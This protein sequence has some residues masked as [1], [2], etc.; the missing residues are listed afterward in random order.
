MGFS[1]SSWF[2]AFV[3]A[4]V[5]T[6]SNVALAAE[7]INFD[8]GWK[9]A[10]GHA[11][12]AKKDFGFSS[13]SFSAF[14]KAGTDAG[15]IGLATSDADWRT[16]DLPHDW[17]VELPFDPTSDLMHGFKPVGRDFPQNSIGW[18]RK[19]FEVP[20]ADKDKRIRITFDGIYRDAYVWINGHLLG[21]NESGYIGQ[22]YDLTDFVKYGSRNVIAVRANASDFEGWFYEGA[23]IY[24]HV[25]LTKS[26][27]V[28]FVEDGVAVTPV[29]LGN[30]AEVVVNAEVRNDSDAAVSQRLKVVLRD[31]TGKAV[32]ES[33]GASVRIGA[34]Q[35][36]SVSARV[37]VAKPSLWSIEDPY[38]YTADVSTPTD[39][40]RTRI[41]FRTVVF[42]PDKGLLLNG[43]VV[44]IQGTCNHQDHAGV[45]AAIPDSLNVW[46]IKQLKGF[47][48][49]AYRSSHNP[50]T[51]EV[52]D[53]CDRLGMLVL[54]ET[55]MFG[56]GPEA[57]S[58]LTRLVKRD[59]NHA[60][61][62]FWSIGNEE[63]GTQNSPESARIAKTM[64]N[65]IRELDPTRPVTFGA[66]NGGELNGINSV[67]DVRG[68]NYN[69]GGLDS[70][71]KA[72]PKQHI[73]GSEVGSTVTTRGEYLDDPK[74][75]YVAAYD[76][77]R[78]SWGSTAEAW[79][80]TTLERPWFSGGFVWTGFDYRGEPTPYGWPNVN[81]HFGILDTCGF[82]KDLAFY[83]KAW[84]TDQQVLHVLPHWNRPKDPSKPVDVWVFSN[85][86]AVE[87]FLNS[88][89]LGKQ[90]M[91]RGGHLEWKVPYAPGSLKAVGYRDGK[92]AQETLIQTTGPAARI[93]LE[94]DRGTSLSEFNDTVPV[95]V[96][97][98]DADGRIVPEADQNIQ[99]ETIGSGKIIGV[100][101]GDPSSHEPDVY[102]AKPNAAVIGG[103]KMTMADGDPLKLAVA[104]PDFD[105]AG[106]RPADLGQNQLRPGEQGVFRT[107]FDG[108]LVKSPMSLSVGPIDD[109]G[110]VFLNG[111]LL[112]TTKEWNASH[113]FRVDGKIL[114]GVNEL[115]IV[116]KNTGGEGGFTGGLRLVGPDTLPTWSRSVFHGLAQVIVQAN[117]NAAGSLV[118]RA[119]GKGLESAE[120]SIPILVIN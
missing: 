107:R 28:H 34:N 27:P 25:W 9:F 44:R 59:R 2:R 116:V 66:N 38:L 96:K 30:A 95:T 98:V 83:Y 101:N 8:S 110:W 23:G 73:H 60:S 4:A 43:K 103:W 40:Y 87:L 24:R 82:E 100:G 14:G 64:M 1:P 71:H 54:D 41:G 19:S 29:V 51:P 57:L 42:D 99:F 105:T 20:V 113:S 12:D 3:V 16:I 47:G 56:S 112:G 33:T 74:K 11:S 76:V 46:R 90:S 78:L 97:V 6:G 70:Y 91:V 50:P 39:A 92:I 89:S 49:N 109:L 37:K 17:A 117:K 10:L 108:G 21:R 106:W 18:Y 58:Q 61:V 118:I 13:G 55:R 63:W 119:K 77:Q 53:A 79:W 85:H 84:W 7:R 75:A 120:L 115:A 36:A 22:T 5:C 80:K 102:L 114:N 86:D 62:I 15:P 93:L 26:E 104:K 111:E 94:I 52:L 35:T 88:K 32:G 65:A 67:V 31:R 72:R 45:G 81:S 48:C 69:L 68:F